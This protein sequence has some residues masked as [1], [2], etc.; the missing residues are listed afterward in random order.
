VQLA[1][2]RIMEGRE[3]EIIERLVQTVAN[4]LGIANTRALLAGCYARL[5][6]K[7]E[8]T[9]LISADLANGFRSCPFDYSWSTS[10]YWLAETVSDLK[11]REPAAALYT[12]LKPFAANLPYTG[13]SVWEIGHHSLGRLATVLDRYD[14]ADAHFRPATETHQRLRA[15]YLLASTRIA[16]PRCSPA[17]PTMTTTAR[18]AI[19][20]SRPPPSPCNPAMPA[21]KAKRPRS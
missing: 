14:D 17:A 3:P 2:I 8:A 5:G 19:S 9:E 7:N 6:Q 11:L 1:N 18:P 20:P 21:S 10:I 16:W 4:N 12:R 15:P 13:P